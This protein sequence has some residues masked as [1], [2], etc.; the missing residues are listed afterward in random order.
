MEP[1]PSAASASAGRSLSEPWSERPGV[2]GPW[3]IIGLVGESSVDGIDVGERQQPMSTLRPT[4]TPQ[5]T[6]PSR[7]PASVPPWREPCVDDAGD[8]AGDAR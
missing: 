2:I 6:E 1:P 8:D 7:P 3:L 5:W 4:V